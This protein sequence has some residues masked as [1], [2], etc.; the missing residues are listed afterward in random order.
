MPSVDDVVP[1]Q[2]GD[3]PVA[4]PLAASGSSSSSQVPCAAANSTA[5]TA[6]DPSLPDKARFEE[7]LDWHLRENLH[8]DKQ[9]K[10]FMDRKMR[11]DIIYCLKNP[12]DTSVGTAQFRF[13]AK[14]TCK[15]D[16]N[17][18]VIKIRKGTPAALKD[19][20]H[21][22]LCRAHVDAKHGGRDKTHKVVKSRWSWIPKEHVG[23]FGRMCP[24]CYPDR[25]ASDSYQPSRRA[26]DASEASDSST[27]SL[28]ASA[29]TIR[30]SQRTRGKVTSY[31]PDEDEDELDEQPD[32]AEPDEDYVEPG[33]EAAFTIPRRVEDVRRRQVVVL[34]KERVSA[35]A[36]LPPLPY[37]P[38]NWYDQ[39]QVST[40]QRPTSISPKAL[41]FAS[42]EVPYFTTHY[43]PPFPSAVDQHLPYPSFSGSPPTPL[44]YD[45]DTSF[46]LYLDPGPLHI[47]PHASEQPL[48]PS[49]Y[50]DDE[51]H[52]L[53]VE[54]AFAEREGEHARKALFQLLNTG[55]FVDQGEVHGHGGGFSFSANDTPA[56]SADADELNSDSGGEKRHEAAS[57]LA[58]LIALKASSASP[59][60]PAGQLPPLPSSPDVPTTAFGARRLSRTA[61][62]RDEDEEGA[63]APGSAQKKQRATPPPPPPAWT[64]AITA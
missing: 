22:I 20:I 24:T 44:S 46:D 48:F 61:S 30:T 1:P 49:A 63:A 34:V 41:E 19:D 10:H 16:A 23:I 5:S 57:T 42:N 62:E 53:H 47:S 27:D 6:G 12:G 32:S 15:L 37:P 50:F 56:P 33:E 14:R 59:A 28:P 7:Y 60:L 43:S 40:G 36:A 52:Y 45:A 51:R 54:D 38:V 2:G 39:Q 29:S 18:A 26:S 13:W 25:A 9:E 17:G 35:P 11:D 31:R 58:S 4:P 3:I 64:S 8:K 21:E 55:E